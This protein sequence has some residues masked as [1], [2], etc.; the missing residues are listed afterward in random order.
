MTLYKSKAGTCFAVIALLLVCIAGCKKSI[1]INIDGSSTVVPI[2]RAVAEDYRNV[3]QGVKI[4]IGVSGTGGG[5]K[6][7]INGEIDICNASRHIKEVEVEGCVAA[8][9]EVVEFTIAFDGLSVVTNNENDWCDNISTEELKT[10]WQTESKGIVL[11]WNKVNPAWPD[12]ELKLYG[13]G[14][15]SGTFEYFTKAIN[16]QEY[17]CRSDYT[18]SENDNA[19][20]RGIEGNKG[21]LC[22]LGYAYYAENKDR[23][24]LIAVDGGAG[25]VLPT[26]NT[27][28]D[29]SYEPLS[30]PLFIYVT[31]SSLYRPEVEN[32]V[33]FYLEHAGQ[34]AEEVGYVAVSDNVYQDNFEKLDALLAEKPT[35]DKTS[36]EN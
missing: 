5:M 32:F 22:F 9:I 27:V 26:S 11:N 33:R 36:I 13:P 8:G 23:L 29:G 24:K 16:G 6:K 12:E 34:L 18:A 17:S 35:P 30:R 1:S 2:T 25:P 19:L 4:P 31:K 10:I 28:R 14:I 20:V 3:G 21:A 7:L 15:D